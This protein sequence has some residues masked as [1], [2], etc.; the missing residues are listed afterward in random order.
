MAEYRYDC[1]AY[2]AEYRYLLEFWLRMA[3]YRYDFT[4]YRAEYR[5][6]NTQVRREV[7]HE[8]LRPEDGHPERRIIGCVGG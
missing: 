8:R 3:E 7:R 6:T 2:R 4:A 5:L 1:T